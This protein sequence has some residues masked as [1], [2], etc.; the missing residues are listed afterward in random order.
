MREMQQT[1]T[2]GTKPTA[3]KPPKNTSS[4]EA[5]YIDFEEIK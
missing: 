3:P 4:R 1:D 5:D 2:N